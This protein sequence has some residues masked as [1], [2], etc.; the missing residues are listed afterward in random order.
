MGSMS[1]CAAVIEL[2]AGCDNVEKEFRADSASQTASRIA[3]TRL[4]CRQ[5]VSDDGRCGESR[6]L[7]VKVIRRVDIRANGL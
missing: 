4:I 6:L 7:R 2:F 3:T 5:S 1:F